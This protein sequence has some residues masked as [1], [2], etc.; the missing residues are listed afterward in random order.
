MEDYKLPGNIF[1][2]ES[3]FYYIKKRIPWS[4]RKKKNIQRNGNIIIV[5][6]GGE[7]IHL[8]LKFG[9]IL[10]TTLF[11]IFIKA[12]YREY[13]IN[14]IYCVSLPGH[15][16]EIDMKNT[17]IKLQTLQN[18]DMIRLLESNFRGSIGSVFGR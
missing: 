12:S 16:W 3:F 5:R 18:K 7:F 1:K 13:G 8:G 17:F 14:P 2:T 9:V 11:E 6:N 4:W 10:V 15:T